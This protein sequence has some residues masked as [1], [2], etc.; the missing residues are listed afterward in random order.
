MNFS[1]E[2]MQCLAKADKSKK[3]SIDRGIRRI[4]DFL[5]SLGNYYTTSSCSG[6]IMLIEKPESGSKQDARWLFVSHEKASHEDIKNALEGNNVW[7]KQ[8]G[9]IL[10]VCCRTAEDAQKLLQVARERGFKRSGIISA[11]KRVIVEIVSTEIVEAPVARKG[12]PIANGLYIEAL[13]D[14]ANKNM[15]KNAERMEHFLNGLESLK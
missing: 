7:F 14:S 13:V 10:H 8:E 15:E 12:K 5:N 4:V 6:R 11:N 1:H 2:K 9:A 3:Q